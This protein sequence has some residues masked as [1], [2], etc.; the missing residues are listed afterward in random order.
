[1]QAS[2]RDAG[3]QD[4]VRSLRFQHIGRTFLPR[5]AEHHR[6]PDLDRDRRRDDAELRPRERDHG[7]KEHPVQRGIHEAAA[8]SHDDDRHHERDDIFR[9]SEP[10]RETPGGRFILHRETCGSARVGQHVAEIVHPVRH[11]AEAVGVDARE[12]FH[13]AQH[14]VHAA[15]GTGD[16][17]F[18]PSFV[19]AARPLRSVIW[20][21]LRFHT[22]RHFILPFRHGKRQLL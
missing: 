11:Y 3:V 9:S 15:C 14:Q 19:C 6:K 2:G 21:V 10:A 18:H 7:M 22:K 17:K 16:G 12:H 4:A 8:H 20:A 5:D 13:D 1:M